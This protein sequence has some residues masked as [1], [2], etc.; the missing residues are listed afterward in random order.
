[1]ITMN[2]KKAQTRGV[3]AALMIGVTGVILLFIVGFVLS[4]GANLVEDLRGSATAQNAESAMYNVSTDA[5]GG[6]D[7]VSGFQ[8]T[9]GLIIAA[10]L[11]ISVLMMLVGVVLFA[12]ARR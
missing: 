7:N 10:V 11:V 1:M 12:R 4:I 2:D 5:L 3:T 9:I 6:F 8:P